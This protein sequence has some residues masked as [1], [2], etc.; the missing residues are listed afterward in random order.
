MKNKHK[1]DI[2]FIMYYPFHWYV[3]KN[4]YKHLESRS[5]FIID[6]CM[7]DKNDGIRT[8]ETMVALLEKNQVP[9]KV[10]NKE[11]YLFSDYLQDFFGQ[12]KVMVS[13]WETGSVVLKETAHIFKVNTTYGAGKELTM[14]RPSRGVYDLILSYGE[15]DT[16]LFSLF[17]TTVPIG[18]PKFDDFYNKT[19]DK[20]LIAAL[21]L[22]IK[23]K[24]ILYLP[25]H[26]DLSSFKALLPKLVKIS[27]R[28]NILVKMHYYLE[29]EESEFLKETNLK[30]VL[31]LNDSVD[32]ITLLSLCDMAISDN[33]S[34]IFDVIQADKPLLVADFWSKDFLDTTHKTPTFYKRGRG[35][36]LTYS[37]SIEQVIK[38]ESK[39]LSFTAGDDLEQKVKD[40]LEQDASFSKNRAALRN[41]LFA[42]Q[43]GDCGRRGAEA[44]I[45]LVKGDLISKKGIFFHAYETAR[46]LNSRVYYSITNLLEENRKYKNLF[47]ESPTDLVDV[48]VFD[49]NPESTLLTLR[50]LVES[51]IESSSAVITEN[52][53]TFLK[54]Q[55]PQ[56]KFFKSFHD[57]YSLHTSESQAGILFVDSGIVLNKID[58]AS[59]LS[60]TKSNRELDVVVVSPR[61]MKKVSK[62]K[63]LSLTFVDE[64]FSKLATLV[65][66]RKEYLYFDA[67]VIFVSKGKVERLISYPQANSISNVINYLNIETFFYTAFMKNIF[68]DIETPSEATDP[69]L[70][71]SKKFFYSEFFIQK[72][73]RYDFISFIKD[74]YKDITNKRS[75]VA[76]TRFEFYSYLIYLRCVFYTENIKKQLSKAS[77]NIK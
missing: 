13:V 1:K 20:E 75:E 57:Y 47:N 3:Y 5:E 76:L 19:L 60:F 67:K 38:K 31:L 11:D 33:S 21:P 22:D 26:S 72:K 29:R 34:A 61:V 42:Y 46:A 14:V 7:F 25:T 39:V 56:V 28:F 23:K 8:L 10:L 68:T 27:H 55:Y 50:S 64:V 45:K 37:D 59:L 9:Y 49:S 36:A 51:G 52:S 77:Q 24:T 43:D 4:I 35:G 70:E 71:Y 17:T 62:V 73:N 63:K 54:S 44:V 58:I 15:R 12:Y 18:N 2:A 53:D 48:V 40:C 41:E 74:V 65:V 30:E 66:T 32:L 16:K 69:L 6:L